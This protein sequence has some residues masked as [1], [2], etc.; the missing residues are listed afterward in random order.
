M[1]VDK[2]HS[3]PEDDSDDGDDDDY[4]DRVTVLTEVDCAVS[5]SDVSVRD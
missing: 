5:V 1:I 4:D 3:L 2:D